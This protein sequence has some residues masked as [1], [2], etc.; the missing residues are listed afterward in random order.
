[1]G[2]CSFLSQIQEIYFMKKGFFYVFL[3]LV[4]INVN[5][6]IVEKKQNDSLK[7]KTITSFRKIYWDNLPKPKGWINDYDK[8]LSNDEE[9]KLDS[10]ISAF[11]RETTIEIAIV[12]IDTINVSKENFEALTLHIAKTWGVGKKG[13][14]NGILVG[15]SKDYRKIRIE[16]GDG[17]TK[18]FSEQET[19]E[20]IDHDFV[21]EFKKGNYYQGMFN[22]VIKIMESLRVKIQK[23]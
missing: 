6:Q 18:I 15:F 21:P 2:C 5:S 8:V 10:L 9:I 17:I 16:L 13:K 22:G 19:S 7:Q 23:E 1:M 12:T 4:V 20:I 11:E 3:F 14:D